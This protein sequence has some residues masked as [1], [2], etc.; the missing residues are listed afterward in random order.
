VR[1]IALLVVVCKRSEVP[2]VVGDQHP[3]ALGSLLEHD[4]VGQP[5]KA[6]LLGG[7]DGVAA[8]TERRDELEVR[9][10]VEERGRRRHQPAIARSF[11]LMMRSISALCAW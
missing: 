2:L 9:A 3:V 1:L 8:R 4:V 5:A 6:G 11:S 7:L 10:L